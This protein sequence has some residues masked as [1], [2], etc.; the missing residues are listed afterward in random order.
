MNTQNT[1]FLDFL[2]TLNGLNGASIVSIKDY[3]VDANRKASKCIVSGYK[4]ITINVNVNRERQKDKNKETLLNLDREAF[5][6][7]F[8]NGKDDKFTFD[9]FNKAV[10]ALIDQTTKVGGK[11]SNGKIKT[12]R[13][14]GQQNQL[15]TYTNI[16]KGLKIHN[17]TKQVYISG[18]FQTSS[19]S[20]KGNLPQ[21]RKTNK[22]TKTKIQDI[23]K[24]ELNLKSF[25]YRTLVL[26]NTELIK[27]SGVQFNGQK[28]TIG[29]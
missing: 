27:T 17:E 16:S 2:L 23:L 20:D 10:N 4:N 3:F 14:N 19:K 25:Q 15:D 5:F 22:Q 6:N 29:L 11:L 28:I 26:S 21:Y 12:E 7:Q 9:V 8:V 18:N 1:N 13:T 24:N